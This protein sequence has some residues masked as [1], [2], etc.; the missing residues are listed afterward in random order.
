MPRLPRIPEVLRF[1]GRVLSFDVECPACG[2]I[3][4]ARTFALERDL[5]GQHRRHLPWN[6]VTGRFR[7]RTCE[8]IYATGLLLYEVAQERGTGGAPPSDR[9]PTPKQREAMRARR[10]ALLVLGRKARGGDALNLAI[11]APCVCAEG[12][13]PDC[14]VHAYIA[15]LLQ[16]ELHR[17]D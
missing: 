11:T 3:L 7:C 5:T 15:E 12:W 10:D 14:P 9:H 8:R 2:T 1:F 6:V 16:Q 17:K 13:S 4:E